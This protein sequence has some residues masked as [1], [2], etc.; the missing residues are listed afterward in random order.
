[1]KAALSVLATLAVA[2][3]L[4]TGLSADDK[5]KT[6]KGTITCAKCDLKES[7]KCATVIKVKEDGKDVVY[8]LDEKAGKKHHSK[9]CQTPMEGEVTGKISE[10]DGKKIVTATKVEFK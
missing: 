2:L 7:A 8:Y 10:K 3:L 9:I 5:E 4:V 1:M 6:L